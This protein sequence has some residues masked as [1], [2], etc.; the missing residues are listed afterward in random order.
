MIG[1]LPLTHYN[2]DEFIAYTVH[3]NLVAD[4][5]NCLCHHAQYFRLLY[6]QIPAPIA[7]ASTTN[8]R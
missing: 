7:R 1:P 5:Y 3:R 4:G 2:K 8:A 6:G